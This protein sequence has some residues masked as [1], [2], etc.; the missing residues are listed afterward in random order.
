MKHL[1]SLCIFILSSTILFAQESKTGQYAEIEVSDKVAEAVIYTGY[2]QEGTNQDTIYLLTKMDILVK[3][4][5]ADVISMSTKKG[6]LTDK[7]NRN[8]SYNW[9]IDDNTEVEEPYAFREKG[10]YANLGVD[11]NIETSNFV[12]VLPGAE[13]AVGYRFNRF[14]SLGAG[15]AFRR[16]T[17]DI[18]P[19]GI[20]TGFVETRGFIFKKKVS[21]YYRF[22]VGYG[23]PMGSG[24]EFRS[25]Y[26]SSDGGMYYGAG[27]GLRLLGNSTIQI[28]IETGYRNQKATYYNLNFGPFE[29]NYSFNKHYIGVSMMY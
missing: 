9:E 17:E 7:D 22:A 15:F 11:V 21:P 6:S 2:I 14:L 18:F 26:D 4:P 24:R 3:I 20:G 19:N 28:N 27:I 5:Y 12:T 29:R 13:F 10:I 1:F 25:S 16:Y 23:K 8:G